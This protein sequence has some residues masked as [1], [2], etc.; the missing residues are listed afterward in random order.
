MW[1]MIDYSIGAVA[2]Y[3]FFLILIAIFTKRKDQTSDDFIIGSRQMGFWLTALAAHASDMSSWIFMAY[4]SQI[5]T[6]G[7][8]QAWLAIGLTVFMFL[9]WTFIAPKLRSITEKYNSLTLTSFFES[10]YA[11]TS[12]FLRILTVII[13][14]IFYI[15]YISAGLVGLGF[16]LEFL[17]NLPY[18]WGVFVGVFIIVPYLFVGGYVTLAWTDFFQGL[19]LMFV[20]VFVPA[21]ALN[22]AINGFDAIGSAIAQK[23]NFEWFIPNMKFSTWID[24][25]FSITGWGL[26]YF[27]QPHILTK[28]MGI[29][30]VEDMHKSKWVGISWQI[31]SLTGATFIGLVGIAYFQG[32]TI[33][34]PEH[35]F[36]LLTKDTIQPFFAAFFLCAV[37]GATITCM[38][39][40][41]LVLASNCTEDLWKRSIRKNASSKELLF[42]SRL[43]IFIIAAIAF[44]IATTTKNSIFSL[45]EYAWYGLGSSFGPLV[46][47]GIYTKKANRLGAISGIIVGSVIAIFWPLLND[48]YGWTVPTL[49]PAFFTSLFTIWLISSITQKR[50]SNALMHTEE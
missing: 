25:L 34:N 41:I 5:F 29:G 10:R 49:I 2:L 22:T 16:L 23:P 8:F 15:V 36:I 37:I 13:S 11:D 24:I 35:V 6:K 12:G 50:G 7:L 4:P 33:S 43:S 45:V 27:G 48:H 9:N 14:L 44:I 31:I 42:I 46:I 20:I 28:F 32:T 21:V 39:S 38:D 40:Q 26:G 19:F 3:I 1:N 47:L 30:K 17:F 18:A